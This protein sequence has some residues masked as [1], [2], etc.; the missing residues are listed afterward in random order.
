LNDDRVL[1]L[2]PPLVISDAELDEATLRI[3]R[4]AAR[5]KDSSGRK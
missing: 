1:R 3:E 4:A 2:A 5:A